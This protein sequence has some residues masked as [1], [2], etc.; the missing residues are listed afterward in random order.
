MCLLT[1]KLW[2]STIS[3]HSLV[4]EPSAAQPVTTRSK[5]SIFSHSVIPLCAPSLVSI[6]QEVDGE[7]VGCLRLSGAIWLEK[8]YILSR[9]GPSLVL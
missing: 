5:I 7:A 6:S 8:L 3:G 1:R 4:D 2:K 9:V